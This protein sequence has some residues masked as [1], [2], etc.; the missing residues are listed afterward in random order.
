MK[1]FRMKYSKFV[2]AMSILFL[3]LS[4]A[5]VLYFVLYSGGSYLPAWI[6]TLVIV[7]VLLSSLSIP[8]YVILSHTSVEVHCVMD[9]TIVGLND[10]K[11]VKPLTKRDVKYCLP[12]GG[13][14]C[15]FGYYGYYLDIRRMRLLQLYARKWSNFVEIK[16]GVKKKRLVVGVEEPELF[17]E[18]VKSSIED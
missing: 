10:I 4:L 16:Y 18:M 1:K 15:F 2:I 12:L 6:L 17:I 9:L 7:V 11:E 13:I 14:S 3:L 8:R 5:V